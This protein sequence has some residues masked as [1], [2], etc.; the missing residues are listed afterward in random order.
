MNKLAPITTCPLCGSR[1]VRRRRI[2]I[3]FSTG[4]RV[5]GVPADVC[6]SCGERFLDP[7]AMGLLRH[8]RGKKRAS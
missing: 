8:S 1:Q 2:A 3:V 7:D 5:S 4:R 6:A